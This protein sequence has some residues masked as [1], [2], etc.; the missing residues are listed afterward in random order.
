M[1]DKQGL[2]Y[3]VC[4]QT[5][6]AWDKILIVV[7]VSH[8]YPRSCILVPAG[9]RAVST[10]QAREVRALR[11]YIRGWNTVWMNC[12]FNTSHRLLYVFF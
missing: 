7:P 12:I 2:D 9:N 3:L 6:I 1:S 10:R 8:R 4:R 5:L 11:V